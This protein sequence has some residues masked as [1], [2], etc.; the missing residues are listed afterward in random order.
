MGWEHLPLFLVERDIEDRRLV[1]F[2]GK[3]LPGGTV[4][5]LAA[6]LRD[7]PH[8]PVANRLR[9]FIEEQAPSFVKIAD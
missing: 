6:R 2:T 7:R 1:P 3:H 4:E 8:G 9:R 5:L